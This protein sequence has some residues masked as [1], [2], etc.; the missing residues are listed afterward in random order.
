MQHEAAI[1]PAP[2][3]TAWL[4]GAPITP[5]QLLRCAPALQISE[6]VL[7][8]TLDG[9]RDPAYWPLPVPPP[10]RLGRPE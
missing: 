5:S 2:L 3:I 1:L 10:D 7:L 4:D 8:A 9:K 6:D